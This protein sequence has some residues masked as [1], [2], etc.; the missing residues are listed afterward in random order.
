MSRAGLRGNLASISKLRRDL[1]EFPLS[2]AYAVAQKAGP[3]LST[4]TR[5]AYKGG[6]TVYG[7]SR[8]AGKY[9]PLDLERS[10]RTVASLRF[11]ANGSQVRAVLGTPWAKYLIGKYR[12]LPMGFIPVEWS[13]AL[14]AIVKAERLAP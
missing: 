3:E 4:L 6:R 5:A 8:P 2:L 10:G 9:G 12:V 14:A 13:R 1:K 11:E 7:D